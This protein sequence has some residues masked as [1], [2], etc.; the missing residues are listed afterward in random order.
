[1]RTIQEPIAF[2]DKL[3]RAIDQAVKKTMMTMAGVEPTMLAHL[4]KNE[5]DSYGDVSGIMS[6]VHPRSEGTIVLS[7]QKETIFYILARIYKRSFND[8]DFNVKDGVG[9]LINVIYGQFRALTVSQ[10]NGMRLT[11]PYVVTCDAH[12]V[13]GANRGPTIVI[14]FRVDGHVFH[15]AFQLEAA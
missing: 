15:I 4:V 2:D 13:N 3:L 6:L 11:P 8:I 5:V 10:F 1:M 9:E 7:F 14:P 12:R